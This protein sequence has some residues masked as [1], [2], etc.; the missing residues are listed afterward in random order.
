VTYERSPR[1]RGFGWRTTSGASTPWPAHTGIALT[2]G[3]SGAD[4]CH[5]G[6]LLEAF[7]AERKRD[8]EWNDSL[9]E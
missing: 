5:I 6:N 7:V 3:L 2:E 4:C 8:G 1:S 9:V